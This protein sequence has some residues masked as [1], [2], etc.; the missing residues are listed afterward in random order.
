MARE[1]FRPAPHVPAPRVVVLLMAGVLVLAAGPF[2][3]DTARGRP[4]AGARATAGGTVTAGVVV[5]R[6]APAPQ[7]L[8]HMGG[9]LTLDWITQGGDAVALFDVANVGDLAL[10]DQRLVLGVD[11]GAEGSAPDPIVLT[12]C[13]GGVWDPNGTNCPG[14]LLSLGSD[15][16]APLATGVALDPGE[17][18]SVRA[19]TRRRTAAQTRLTVEVLVGRADVRA[20][21]TT[22]G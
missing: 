19:T 16:D 9:P 12:A 2:G 4:D 7:G 18:L 13:D 20:A 17:R 10:S 5:W 8:P 14:T 11:A 21:T 6:A 3:R 1:R 15:R 22:S